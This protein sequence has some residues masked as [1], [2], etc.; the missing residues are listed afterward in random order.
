MTERYQKLKRKLEELFQLD[1]PELD[2]GIY[3]RDGRRALVIWRCL[4]GEPEK[5]NLVLDEWFTGRGFAD[6]DPPFDVVYVNGGN[7]LDG[8]R[9]AEDTWRVRLIEEDFHRL[10]F[11]ESTP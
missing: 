4:T 5:D 10:M 3:R 9:R 1:R 6:V 7:N 2:F 11:A 8:L